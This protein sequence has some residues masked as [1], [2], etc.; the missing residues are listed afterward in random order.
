M[1]TTYGIKYLGSKK[2]LIPF[3][4]QV[5]SQ[6]PEHEKTMIDVFT[7]TT[8]VAQAFRQL[9]YKVTTSDLSYASECFSAL[10]IE[11]PNLRLLEPFVS[12][13]NNVQP[14]S[15]WLTQSYC[16][17]KSKTGRSIRVWKPKNGMKADAIREEIETLWMANSIS[18]LDKRAL[19]ALLI[20][21][22]DK[23]DNTVGV[24]QSYLVEWKAK[25]AD[26]D[27][28]LVLEGCLDNQTG[29]H[30]RGSSQ[31]IEYPPASIA[32]LDPPYTSH[33]Y[34][35]YYHIWDSI[36]IWDKPKL[37]LSTNRREDRIFSQEGFDEDFDSPWYNAKESEKALKDLI[38]R[39]PVK[40]ILLSY[41][42]E[43]LLSEEVLQKTLSEHSAIESFTFNEVDYRRNIM[44]KIG[45]GAVIDWSNKYNKEFVIVIEKK[46]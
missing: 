19:I 22:L 6:L 12:H 45:R 4:Q 36:A 16:E 14:I 35:S 32:Y 29:M 3:I 1:S 24:Q 37:G 31:D 18:E 5:A 39:L 13:L 44:S 42:N 41:N 8:R 7:G 11:H 46:I 28:K 9:D 43:G 30:I 33:N 21:A 34:G 40:Y 27:L 20:I 10:F 2:K 26:H 23:V 38:S 25:R 15:G 17:A